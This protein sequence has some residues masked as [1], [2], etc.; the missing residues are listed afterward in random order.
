MWKKNNIWALYW[1]L[2]YSS[3]FLLHFMC[4]VNIAELLFCIENTENN[5]DNEMS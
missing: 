5:L 4:Y 1:N 3:N 2:K